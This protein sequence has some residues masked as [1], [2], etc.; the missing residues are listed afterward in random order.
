MSKI[1]AVKYD[2]NTNTYKQY[3]SW[4]NHPENILLSFLYFNPKKYISM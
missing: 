4:G 3:L 2:I 1:K